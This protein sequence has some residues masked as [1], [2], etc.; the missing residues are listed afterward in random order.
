MLSRTVALGSTE[1]VLTLW[2]IA[3]KNLRYL[4]QHTASVTCNLINERRS[5]S[6]GGNAK[7]HVLFG[8]PLD[9]LKMC[10][11]NSSIFLDACFTEIFPNV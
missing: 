2:G 10:N 8:R 3:M 6:V 5:C 7:G 1:P 4:Q 11:S 9:F